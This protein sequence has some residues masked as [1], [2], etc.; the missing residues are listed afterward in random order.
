MKTYF[1]R[2]SIKLVSAGKTVLSAE[3][4]QTGVQLLFYAAFGAAFSP[5]TLRMK[6]ACG[7]T[8]LF[9]FSR[10]AQ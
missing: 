1:F 10:L 2:W 4:L 5:R 8:S 9:N 6:T 7:V 3:I